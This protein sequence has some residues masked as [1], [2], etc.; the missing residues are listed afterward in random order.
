MFEKYQE[1]WRCIVLGIVQGLTEFLPISSSF[2]LRLIPDLLGWP[3]IGLGLSAFLHL[4]TLLAVLIYFGKDLLEIAI[5]TFKSLNS[6]K[7][8]FSS[9]GFKIII[10]SL[11][12]ILIGFFAH[13]FFEKIDQNLTITT[14][15]LI[16]I[17]ILLFVSDL[18]PSNIIDL[19]KNINWWQALLI[20]FGQATAL[21][22]GVS[23]SGST[24]TVARLLGFSRTESARFSFLM[25]SPV[26]LGAGLYEVLKALKSTKS[27]EVSWTAAVMGGICSAIV[28]Y[29][30]IKFLLKFLQTQS[31]FPFMLYRVIIGLFVLFGISKGFFK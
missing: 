1:I 12:A 2:H 25:G 4:G 10:A 8:F 22:S 13:D 15:F 3:S 16:L 5:E 19:E 31:L 30:A 21:I 26:I 27:L 18:K 28:G 14:I 9:L 23:R 29:F 11:P 24:I 6:P 20:G 17:G 7:N